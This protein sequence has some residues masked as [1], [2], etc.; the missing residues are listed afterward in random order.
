MMR[1]FGDRH[2]AGESGPPMRFLHTCG[3]EFHAVPACKACGQVVRRGEVTRID[4]PRE[5][6]S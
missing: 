4:D 1:E 5:G 6:Q 3:E 2:L